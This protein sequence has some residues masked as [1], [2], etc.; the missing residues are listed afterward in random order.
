[1][2][3]SRDTEIKVPKSGKS[4][5]ESIEEIWETW[6]ND[7][8]KDEC[9]VQ[10]KVPEK[11]W[12]SGKEMGLLRAYWFAGKVTTSDDSVGTSSMGAGFV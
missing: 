6:R 12:W 2:T 3:C 10:L 4:F 1:M 9:K 7:T 8:P 5:L 11:E